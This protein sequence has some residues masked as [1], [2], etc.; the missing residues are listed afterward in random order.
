M[1]HIKKV[2]FWPVGLIYDYGM[3]SPIVRDGKLSGFYE[4]WI[5][6]RKYAVDMA[7]FA[8]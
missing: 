1:R 2:A 8:V 3:S 4:S 6:N 7:G 5:G